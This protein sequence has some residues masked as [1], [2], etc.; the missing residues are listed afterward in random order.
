MTYTCRQ[1][2][3][4]WPYTNL[5]DYLSIVFYYSAHPSY[6]HLFSCNRKGRPFLSVLVPYSVSNIRCARSLSFFTI[7]TNSLI[8][9]H[10]SSWARTCRC[11]RSSENPFLHP[12]LRP[13][14]SRT[15]PQPLLFSGILSISP[16]YIYRYT[17]R[18]YGYN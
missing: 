14:P 7:C 10:S 16:Y 1:C 17:T 6:A 3:W 12:T 5:Y 15:P 9:Y 18:Y 4:P 2:V 8:S 13:A 11:F